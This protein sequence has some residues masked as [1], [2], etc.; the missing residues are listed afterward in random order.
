MPRGREICAVNIVLYMGFL[1]SCLC[2]FFV[3]TKSPRRSPA[4]GRSP[5]YCQDRAA[6]HGRMFHSLVPCC[7]V[8][9]QSASTLHCQICEM[10]LNL[11]GSIDWI[12]TEQH[13]ASSYL[14]ALTVACWSRPLS[15]GGTV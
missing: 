9:G 8:R 15:V 1:L 4:V 12:G 5:R 13:Q 6:C 2:W 7:D 10:L 14:A 3:S 11:C